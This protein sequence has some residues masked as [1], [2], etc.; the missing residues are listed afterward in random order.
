MMKSKPCF[1]GGFSI[2]EL[3]C[4]IMLIALVAGVTVPHFRNTYKGVQ[5]TI[6]AQDLVLLMRYAQ[7]RAITQGIKTRVIFDADFSRFWLE[8]QPRADSSGQGENEFHRPSGRLAKRFEIDPLISLEMDGDS[9]NFTEDGQI[10]AKRIYL[11]QK[12]NCYTVST[13]DQSH[14]VRIF[15]GRIQ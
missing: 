2:L 1:V 12:D 10:E 5:L 8:E 4:V 14:R 3:L 6:I 9:I 11:C 13:Q 7:D 15:Q